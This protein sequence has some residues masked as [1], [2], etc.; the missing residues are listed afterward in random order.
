M[1]RVFVTSATFTGDLVS[2]GKKDSCIASADAICQA[3]AELG[4]HFVAYLGDGQTSA[5]THVV[6]DGPYSILDR[7]TVAYASRADIE[8]GTKVAL[9][10]ESNRAVAAFSS[11]WSGTTRDAQAGK[12]CLDWTREES[13]IQGD[14]ASTGYVRSTFSC[15]EPARLLCIE[16]RSPTPPIPAAKLVRMRLASSFAPVTGSTRP[17][18]GGSMDSSCLRRRASSSELR[19]TPST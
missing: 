8:N 1:L 10:D 14:S 4:G 2:A 19:G 5:L 7:T 13:E 16:Q 6:D 18:T 11:F 3:A 9:T 17:S 15:D 12:D